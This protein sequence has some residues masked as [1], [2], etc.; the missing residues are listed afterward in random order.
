M[1]VVLDAS[2]IIAFLRG[3][4]GA[5]VVER[6]FGSE[7]DNLYVH[8]LNLRF[9]LINLLDRIYSL[10]DRRKAVY[11]DDLFLPPNVLQRRSEERLVQSF[12]RDRDQLG[13]PTPEIGSELLLMPEQRAVRQSRIDP[14]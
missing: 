4:P 7:N 13:A 14:V 10:M 6:Y 3:E 12:H 1:N 9:R 8:A 11:D 5:D 2:A